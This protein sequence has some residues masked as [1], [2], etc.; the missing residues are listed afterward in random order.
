MTVFCSA[1][2]QG[3][4][5][6]TSFGVL[7]AVHPDMLESTNR[8]PESIITIRWDHDGEECMVILPYLNYCRA[9]ELKNMLP[10]SY[11]L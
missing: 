3:M 7:S 9:T 5:T 8:Q 10:K 6:P 4:T 1:K 11:F 2:L